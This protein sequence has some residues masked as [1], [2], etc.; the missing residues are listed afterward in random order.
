MTDE[1]LAE[2]RLRC[3]AATEG[4]WHTDCGDVWAYDEK[5]EELVIATIDG[6]FGND[7][8]DLAF[9]A[10]ARADIPAL[11]AE[12]ERLRNPWVSVNESLPNDTALNPVLVACLWGAVGAVYD[13]GD[14]YDGHIKVESVTHW[15]PMPE[16]PGADA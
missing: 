7:D 11:L 16:P 15:M 8:A 6:A 1:Q 3:E 4:P 9:I 5:S 10:H 14:W 12:V 2:I 13:N